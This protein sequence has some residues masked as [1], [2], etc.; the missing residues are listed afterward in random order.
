LSGAGNRQTALETGLVSATLLA[1]GVTIGKHW[2][3][4]TSGAEKYSLALAALLG[5]GMV[6]VW[7]WAKMRQDRTQ[8]TPYALRY[9]STAVF[10]LNIAIFR[11]LS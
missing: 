1:L 2:A 11:L 3:I 4:L 6:L 10:V 8:A 7:Y 5:T 9:L